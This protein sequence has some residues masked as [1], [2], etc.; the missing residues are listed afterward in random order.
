[1]QDPSMCTVS[2]RSGAAN[3][4]GEARGRYFVGDSSIS[5]KKRVVMNSKTLI[6]REAAWMVF[7]DGS[8]NAM[9]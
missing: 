6:L 5:G 7:A 3:V 4:H 8:C 2:N 9:V 1:M